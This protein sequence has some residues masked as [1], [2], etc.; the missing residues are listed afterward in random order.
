M[1]LMV[2]IQA[3]LNSTRCPGKVLRELNNT[4]LLRHVVDS[5]KR[6]GCKYAVLTSDMGTDLEIAQFC[7]QNSISCFRGNLD[8]VAKRFLDAGKYFNVDAFMRISA[9]SPF[10]DWKLMSSGLKVFEESKPDMLTNV[11][12]RSYPKGQSI[13][14]LSYDLFRREYRNFC[15]EGDFEHVTKY[16]YRNADNFRIINLLQPDN[17][18][19]SNIQLSVDTEDDFLKTQEMFSRM[20]RPHWDYSINELVELKEKCYK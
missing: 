2:F 14:I 13:E 7:T 4:P 17:I 5:V 11:M 19:Y 16:F 15:E 8:N 18:D 10:I 12:P 1:N 6:V 3:R 20:Q 9:D